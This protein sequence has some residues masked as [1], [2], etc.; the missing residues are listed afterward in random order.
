MSTPSS[1]CCASVFRTASLCSSASVDLLKLGIHHDILAIL[2]DAIDRKLLGA[3]MQHYCCNLFYRMSQ[4]EG[5]PRID[6][7]GDPAGTVS[8][9]DAL[10]AARSVILARA[11]LRERKR[12]EIKPETA[13]EIAPPPPP[14]PP[15]Q[16]PKR[17]GLAD[18]RAA[19]LR[20]KAAAAGDDRSPA[21]A[22]AR[23]ER[24]TAS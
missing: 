3:A 14:P 17:L 19:A 20:R 18:L 23:S 24:L 8:E 4:K 7:N 12:I 6:L 9:A 2:G 5:A 10:S 11:A 13:P 1:N 16:P 21:R 15:P 22:D